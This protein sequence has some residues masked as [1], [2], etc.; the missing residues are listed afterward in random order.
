MTDVGR[1]LRWDF[2]PIPAII[3]HCNAVPVYRL[4]NKYIL[5]LF[6]N[7]EKIFQLELEFKIDELNYYLSLAWN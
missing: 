7:D 3:Y 6:E 1:L 4:Y 2:G 5:F